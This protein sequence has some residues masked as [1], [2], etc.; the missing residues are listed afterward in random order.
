MIAYRPNVALILR[1]EDGRILI[2]ERSDF[3]GTWQFPQGGV[4][5]GEALEQ[6]L[7]REVREEISLLPDDYRVVEQHGPYRYEFEP[8]RTKEGYGGQEQ[9]YFLADFCGDEAHILV[10]PSAAEFRAARW[11]LPG[12]LSLEW[13]APLKR[14][15][16]LSVFRD[17]FGV[18]LSDGRQQ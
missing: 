1:R 17:F 10:Q 3:H 12:Q 6:A 7:A 11:I 13:V 4:N 14:G 16:Y 18:D 5:P 8:G 2:C 15:V 9:T